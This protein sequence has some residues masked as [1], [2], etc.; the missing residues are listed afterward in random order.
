MYTN[1]GAPGL[2]IP[3]TPGSERTQKIVEW[4]NVNHFTTLLSKSGIPVYSGPTVFALW[5]IRA[6][7][8]YP[9]TDNRGTPSTLEYE[10]PAA[11]IWLRILGSEIYSWDGGLQDSHGR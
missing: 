3:E 7:C 1:I 11:L 10:I 2:V 4:L 5:Q 8:E 6:A 9:E